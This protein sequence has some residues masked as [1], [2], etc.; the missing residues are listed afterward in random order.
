M[1]DTPSRLHPP[2]PPLQVADFGI[3]KQLEQTFG[4]AQ[5]FVGTA[6]Y[7]APERVHG[8]ECV[9]GG[10]G[11]GGWGGLRGGGVRGGGRRRRQSA[12]LGMGRGGWVRGSGSGLSGGGECAPRP[13]AASFPTP[14]PRPK[15]FPE[16]RHQWRSERSDPPHHP[17]RPGA[18]LVMLAWLPRRANSVPRPHFNYFCSLHPPGLSVRRA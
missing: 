14:Q 2:F 12:R 10:R 16:H 8:A 3:S 5:S 13:P 15:C 18:I 6:T 11:W 1:C 9:L 4:V 7:M 17:M